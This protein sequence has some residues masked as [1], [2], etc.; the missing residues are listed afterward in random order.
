MLL[1]V[2]GVGPALL[3]VTECEELEVPTVWLAKATAAGLRLTAVPVPVKGTVRTGLTGSEDAMV[4]TA[5]RAPLAAGVKLTVKEQMF[6]AATGAEHVP[7]AKAKSDAFAP[8]I[9]ML[10]IRRVASP[11]LETTRV[12]GALGVAI[13]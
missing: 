10:L 5:V 1:I 7:G 9:E 11:L 13:T 2:S 6:R 8:P 12:W 4:R 3:I